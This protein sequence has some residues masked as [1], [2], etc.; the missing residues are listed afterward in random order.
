M[1]PTSQALAAGGG[2]TIIN[3]GGVTAIL[4]GI[5]GLAVLTLAIRAAIHA[6]RSN[7]GAVITM[8]GIVALAAMF[9]NLATGNQVGKLGGD[10][11]HQFLNI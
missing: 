10:L 1:P 7:F 11:V 6:H 5:F 8:V 4:V 2:G 3:T 9:Y